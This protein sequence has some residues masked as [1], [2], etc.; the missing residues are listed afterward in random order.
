MIVAEYESSKEKYISYKKENRN[1]ILDNKENFICPNCKTKVIYVDVTF[2]IKHFRHKKLRNCNYE[3]ETE[4]HLFM[5]KRMC[6]FF[7]LNPKEV[8]EFN[9]NFAI[10]DLY[11]KD[12]KVAIECQASQISVKNFVE[13]TLTYH[14]NGIFVLWIWDW[15]LWKNNKGIRM[16]ESIVKPLYQNRIYFIKNGFIFSYQFTGPNICIEIQKPTLC[17]IEG[18]IPKFLDE[19]FDLNNLE[20]QTYTH[21]WIYGG[22]EMTKEIKTYK[23]KIARFLDKYG[24]EKNEKWFRL[25]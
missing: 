15:N 6:E 23:I 19:D 12:K 2:K 17:L 25:K 8:C 3:P 21:K 22:M 20:L 16:M 10:P 14:Q 9:L 13:R 4:T 7:N 5:K 24:R 1:F 11:L 18:G